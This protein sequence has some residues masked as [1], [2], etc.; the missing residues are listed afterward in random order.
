[1]FSSIHH[2]EA[3]VS[4]TRDKATSGDIANSDT[5]QKHKSHRAV[6][7]SSNSVVVIF[8]QYALNAKVPSYCSSSLF[9][10]LE[11]ENFSNPKFVIAITDGRFFKKFSNHS[12]LL[13]CFS[14][15]TVYARYGKFLYL[16]LKL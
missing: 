1:M 9:K 10:K 11:F 8:L 7:V 3:I 2:K 6:A 4:S 5:S 12:V 13:L 14:I 15:H 16:S